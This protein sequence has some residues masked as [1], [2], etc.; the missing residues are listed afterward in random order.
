VDLARQY[1]DY[2]ARYF[3]VLLFVFGVIA[4][5]LGAMQV[6]LAVEALPEGEPGAWGVFVGVCK[7]TAIVVIMSVAAVVVGMLGLFLKKS[8][9]EIVFAARTLLRGEDG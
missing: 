5:L 7:W 2:F 1:E 9:D 8:M 6:A 4:V 3:P